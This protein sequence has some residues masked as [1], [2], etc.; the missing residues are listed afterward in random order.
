MKEGVL[1]ALNGDTAAICSLRC[2]RTYLARL[3]TPDADAQV[4]I[5]ICA[6]HCAC[7][8]FALPEAYYAGFLLVWAWSQSLYC[9]LGCMTERQCCVALQPPIQRVTHA[10]SV[11]QPVLALATAA[12][13]APD[14]LN[15]RPSVVAAALLT[16][17]RLS[18]G[19]P[20]AWPSCLAHL[21]GL[22]QCHSPELAAAVT[23]VRRCAAPLPPDA[24]PWMRSMRRCAPPWLS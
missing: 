8:P 17:Q 23:A 4:T 15:F 7:L 13:H 11:M 2:L 12:L 24:L 14:L 9:G 16:V 19:V 21:T 5:F 10:H 20:P 1:A 18:R 3:G 22:S 6:C